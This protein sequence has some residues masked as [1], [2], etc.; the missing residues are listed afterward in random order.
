M[1]KRKLWLNNSQLM[2]ILFISDLHLKAERP[3]IS[4]AFFAFLRNEAKTADALY[5]LGDFFEVWIGD[6]D[7]SDLSLAVADALGQLADAGVQIYFMPGNRDFLLGE[8]YAARAKMRLIAEPYL[9]SLESGACLL[10]HGDTLCTLDTEY[11]KFRGLVRSSAWQQDFLSKSLNERRAIAKHLRDES[12]ARGQEK[13]GY[14]MDVTPEEVERV[15]QAHR[16]QTLI[17]GHTHRPAV[18]Q[19]ATGTRYV[20]GDWDKSFWYLRFKQAEFELIQ[21]VI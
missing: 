16:V 9:L 14:I 10:M 13:A 2:N 7:L 20:L 21:Q 1:K 18:H 19:Q 6:D 4:A 8:A 5:I 12:Q 3:D 11:L 15:M 17:H